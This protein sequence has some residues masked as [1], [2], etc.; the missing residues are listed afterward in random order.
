MPAHTDDE[1]AAWLAGL[2][3][4]ELAVLA[5]AVLERSEEEIAADVRTQLQMA[6]DQVRAAHPEAYEKARK[7]FTRSET[8]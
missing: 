2:T 7:S 1:L 5:A 8:N 4:V 3:R 6:V